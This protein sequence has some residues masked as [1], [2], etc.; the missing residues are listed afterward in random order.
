M[1][2]M[3]S[4]ILAKT[5]DSEPKDTETSPPH[6]SMFPVPTS[7]VGQNDTP[8]LCL[9]WTKKIAKVSNEIRRFLKKD[10]RK[11]LA[12]GMGI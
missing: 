7:E 5:C 10:R 4:S 2:M 8:A 1:A 9:P 6:A 11:C 12:T 3:L